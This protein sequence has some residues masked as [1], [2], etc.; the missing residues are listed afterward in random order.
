MS[1]PANSTATPPHGMSLIASR[2]MPPA[3]RHRVDPQ[4]RDQW[5]AKQLVG[6]R[7]VTPRAEAEEPVGQWPWVA[8]AER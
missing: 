3:G 2:L 8:G 5:L 6:D 4:N 7:A 1:A